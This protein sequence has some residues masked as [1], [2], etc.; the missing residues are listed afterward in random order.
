MNETWLILLAVLT[1]IAVP[2]P[3][4]HSPPSWNVKPTVAVAMQVSSSRS[5]TCVLMNPIGKSMRKAL[6]RSFTSAYCL[7]EM[8]TVLM[9]AFAFWMSSYVMV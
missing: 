6:M 9:A 1:S 2:V 4:V 5:S 3:S 8:F 7:P